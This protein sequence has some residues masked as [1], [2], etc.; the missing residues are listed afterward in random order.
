[1]N[2][3]GMQL[4]RLATHAETRQ[5][6]V[7]QVDAR[8]HRDHDG[9]LALTFGLEGDL[10]R[11][12]IPRAGERRRGHDL[13]RHTC[14]EAFIARDG[15]PAYHEFNFSPS[16]EWAVHAFRA[17]RDG[18]PLGDDRLAPS[19]VVRRDGDRLEL[20]ALVALDRLSASH[21]HAALR[22]ALSAVVEADDGT[23]SYWAL[24]HPPGRPDF[25][26]ADGFV[27]RLEGPAAFC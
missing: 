22:L 18:G 4:V 15:D 16:C 1:L 14:F 2:E 6:A 11:L 10:A 23:L 17:Y 9:T 12:R 24:R 25:H 3:A 27:L 20:D 5:D 26:H 7:R 21:R 19:M 8:V 13:W